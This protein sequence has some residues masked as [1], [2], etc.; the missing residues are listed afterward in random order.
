MPAV[1]QNFLYFSDLGKPINSHEPNM[2][3]LALYSTIKTVHN[4]L[5]HEVKLFQTTV[6]FYFFNKLYNI[7]F[8]S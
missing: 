4:N 6:Y 5:K 7:N 2:E 1:K 3:F 8:C